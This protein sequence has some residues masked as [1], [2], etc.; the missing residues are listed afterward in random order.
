MRSSCSQDFLDL[1]G[2]TGRSW[3]TRDLTRETYERFRFF[4]EKGKYCMKGTKTKKNCYKRQGN[5]LIDERRPWLFAEVQG[6]GDFKWSHGFISRPSES[7]CGSDCEI[8]FDDWIGNTGTL[9]NSF[10]DTQK[11]MDRFRVI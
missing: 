8:T 7:P 5:K 2:T 6:N 3:F 11:A 1:D 4:R 10:D 9:Y